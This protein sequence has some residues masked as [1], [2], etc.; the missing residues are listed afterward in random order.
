MAEQASTGLT[1]LDAVLNYLR[2]GDNV[3][4]QVDSIDDF[5]AFVAPF[6]KT[7]VSNRPQGNLYAVRR[8]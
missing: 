5:A 6:V 1:G 8:P 2:K 7:A 4:W 3:V